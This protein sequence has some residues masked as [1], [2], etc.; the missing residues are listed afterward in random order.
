MTLDEIQSLHLS[1]NLITPTILGVSDA[2][3]VLTYIMKHDTALTNQTYEY[4]DDKEE[5]QLKKENEGVKGKEESN[6][7]DKVE[8]KESNKDVKEGS[9]ISTTTRSTAAAASDENKKGEKEKEKVTDEESTIKSSSKRRKS[10]NLT[11]HTKKQSKKEEEEILLPNLL[12]CDIDIDVP[13]LFHSR[14]RDILRRIKIREYDYASG[15][16]KALRS[17][18]LSRVNE[19]DA[20][21]LLEDVVKGKSLT[22]DHIPV[23]LALAREAQEGGESRVRSHIDA[24]LCMLMERLEYHTKNAHACWDFVD[25]CYSAAGV[26]H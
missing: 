6:E 5:S 1:N 25:A 26:T 20:K 7:C 8:K 24:R 13:H 18:Q 11:S 14:T 17:V 10:N 9:T 16:T 2:P 15:R 21:Q 19:N 3:I 4:E 22:K 12:S 23:C